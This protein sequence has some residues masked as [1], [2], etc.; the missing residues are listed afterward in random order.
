MR[1]QF[2]VS[3][4]SL[5]IRV[6]L[7]SLIIAT[8]AESCM[9]A[10]SETIGQNL[11]WRTLTSPNLRI[12]IDYP[13]GWS[14]SEQEAG[15]TFLSPKG[16]II[17]LTAVQTGGVSPQDFLIENELPNTRCSGKTN[18]FGVTVRICFDTI[19][20]NYIAYFILEQSA[21]PVRL[22]ALST[23]SRMDLKVFDQMIASL[24]PLVK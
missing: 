21:D 5:L 13:P 11:G 7:S 12:A 24:R 10:S 1:T 2:R 9:T 16:E 8:L 15:V 19:S 20:R 18:P 23:S 4:Y 6:F 14:V 22:L 3:G 17:W